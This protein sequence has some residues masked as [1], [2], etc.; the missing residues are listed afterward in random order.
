MFST[1]ITCYRSVP[2]R[3]LSRAWG[4]ISDRPVPMSLR[5]WVYNKY[6]RMYSVNLD[7]VENE[8][9]CYSSLAEFFSRRLK[10]GVRPIDLS[11]CIVSSLSC[12]L[13]YLIHCEVILCLNFMFCVS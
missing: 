13:F 6:S 1:Q 3:P 9:I 11:H 10:E 8:L 4:W 2:L 12:L 5:H 7:E